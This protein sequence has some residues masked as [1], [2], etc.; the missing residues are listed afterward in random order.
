M[1]WEGH[2]LLCVLQAVHVIGKVLASLFLEVRGDN[3]EKSRGCWVKDKPVCGAPSL[4]RT[5][6][7][8]YTQKG[9]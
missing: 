4:L 9:E 2:Q 5:G 1:L 8:M 7:S 3:R 6:V